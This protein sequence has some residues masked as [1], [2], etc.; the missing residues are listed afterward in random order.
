MLAVLIHSNPLLD[1]GKESEARLRSAKN[2]ISKREMGHKL[3]A[4]NSAPIH[5]PSENTHAVENKLQKILEGLNIEKTREVGTKGIDN[6]EYKKISET[7]A[8]DV[9]KWW[10]EEM[11]YIEPPYKTGTLAQEIELTEKSTFVR[12]YDGE[13]SGMYGG[14]FM[15]ADDIKGLTPSQIQD[16]FAL[17]TTP[18]FVADVELDAGTRIRTGTV[19][20]LFGFKG[21]GQQFDLMGQRVG[22][23]T[24]PRPL[25]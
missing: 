11:G 18:K 9:N 10:K 17:P 24:N 22:N 4:A 1:A 23:F 3:S 15:K 16:K 19:N 12:V 20:P 14:W 2:L 8:E 25:P 7:P 6:V 13:K 21:G 5:I